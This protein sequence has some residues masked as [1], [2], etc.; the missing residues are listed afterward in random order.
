V[1]G[2]SYVGGLLGNAGTQGVLP[3]TN[4]YAT[5]NVTG[6]TNVG[7]LIGISF[8]SVINSYA[9]GSVSGTSNVG[10]LV[11]NNYGAVSNSYATGHVQGTSSSGGLVGFN[12]G[13]ASI[14]NSYA[15]GGVPGGGGLVGDNE[16][17]V[18]DSFWNSD[19][20]AIGIAAGTTTGAAGL[21]TAGMMTM[22]NFSS[23]GWSI[24]DVG[25]STSV[26]RIYEGSTTPLLLSFMTPLTVTGDNT[27]QI[28]GAEPVSNLS[29]V[30]YSLAGAPT[31]GHLF[32]LNNPYGGAINV[33]N[34]APSLYSDQQG[35]DISYVNGELTIRPATLT[36]TAAGASRVYGRANPVLT[37]SITG[38]VGGD[39]LASATSGS[40]TFATTAAPGSNVGNYAIGASG[41]TANN[42]NYVFLNAAGNSAAF[43]ITP[44]TLTYNATA[45]SI[46][47]GHSPTVLSGTLSGFVLTDNLANATAGTV[48]WT[49]NGSAGSA[50]GRYA[51]NGS[52]L[53][54]ENYVFVEDPANATALTVQA[55]SS[56]MV[57]FGLA[58]DVAGPLEANLPASQTSITLAQPDLAPNLA[59]ESDADA[60]IGITSTV[61]A[62]DGI[63]L[64][65][66]IVTDAM[67]PSLRIVRGGVKLPADLV[68][69][70]AH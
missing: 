7:G 48:I 51:I 49:T 67:I 63:A 40:E 16:G 30:S 14:S 23:A 39:T 15:A 22:A 69:V 55:G 38:F 54:A 50:P 35:Y 11:G 19:I 29:G 44:A 5:G 3:V 26:W 8:F 36:V 10:G 64:D 9:T 60:G 34:Y 52:G 61:A 66:R 33:G 43:H 65:K 18:T 41:L 12:Y 59:E 21:T 56:T 28:Y 42:G 68:D 1:S 4:S 37:G 47:A 13:S 25:G 32:N 6:S 70:N 2:G 57:V 53:T 58:P 46:G 20:S 24:S 27:G 31:S 62:S 45:A 17:T